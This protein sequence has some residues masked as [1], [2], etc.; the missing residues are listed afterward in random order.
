VNKPEPSLN[1]R[2]PTSAVF[3]FTALVDFMRCRSTAAELL[4]GLAQNPP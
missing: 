1:R 3:F 4:E 2:D